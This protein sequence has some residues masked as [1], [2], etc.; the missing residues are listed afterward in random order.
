MG[1]IRI[2]TSPVDWA[3]DNPVIEFRTTPDGPATTLATFFRIS[4]SPRGRG[5]AVVFGTDPQAP[6]E[7][8]VGCN[9]V[10]TD[11]RPLAEYLLVNFVTGFYGFRDM[12]DVARLPIKDARDSRAAGD[13]ITTYSELATAEDGDIELTWQGLGKPFWIDFDA[14]PSAGSPHDIHSLVRASRLGGRSRRFGEA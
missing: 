11:N 7:S 3:G 6:I 12:P 13:G 9:A 5:H 8:P 1:G 10:F 14:D 4:T 2:D